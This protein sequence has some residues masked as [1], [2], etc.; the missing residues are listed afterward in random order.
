MDQKHQPRK[1]RD[2]ANVNGADKIPRRTEQRKRKKLGLKK[3]ETLC[4][5]SDSS[6]D[7]KKKFDESYLD[8]AVDRENF[9]GHALSES[10]NSN[11][12]WHNQTRQSSVSLNEEQESLY[13]IPSAQTNGAPPVS[14]YHEQFAQQGMETTQE[15]MDGDETYYDCLDVNPDWGEALFD[16]SQPGKRDKLREIL[17]DEEWNKPIQ[18]PLAASKAE[19]LMSVLKLSLKHNWCLSE[20]SEVLQMLNSLFVRSFLPETPYFLKEYFGHAID[21]ELYAVCPLCKLLVRKFVAGEHSVHCN[22]CNLEIIVNDPSL[23]NF[24]AVMDCRDQIK[25]VIEANSDYYLNIMNKKSNNGTVFKDITDGELWEHFRSKL[26]PEDQMYFMS[27]LFN[28]DAA[29]A[30]ET[31]KYSITP[32]QFVI[33]ETPQDVRVASPIT[34]A[35]YFGKDKPD[36]TSYT[37]VFVEK[38]NDLSN[39]GVKCNIKNEEVVI[40]LFFICACMDCV[41][42]A[43]AQGVTQYNGECGCN[44]CLN[45]GVWVDPEKRKAKTKGPKKRKKGE[46]KE[47]AAVNT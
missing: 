7:E 46:R 36:G 18:V 42:R 25:A 5:S 15:T 30:F 41:A 6:G 17:T 12:S 3:R 14:S 28:C 23:N 27:A 37:K 39:N 34:A 19:V 2:Q 8:R 13:S 38:A 11:C 24:F 9:K 20:T 47:G 1:R 45:P 32:Y 26:S 22:N 44:W 21:V 43:P 4:S 40:K 35:I 29:P 31:S 10:A 16:V 33:N